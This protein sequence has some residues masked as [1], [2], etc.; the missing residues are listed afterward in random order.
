MSYAAVEPEVPWLGSPRFR[1]VLSTVILAALLL[2]L[3]G[4][5]RVAL[6][7]PSGSQVFLY[8]QTAL[9]PGKPASFRAF[10]L[11]SRDR[12]PLSGAA[13]SARLVSASGKSRPLAQ[14]MTGEDGTVQILGEIPPD[15]PEG[16]YRLAVEVD[17]SAGTS[18]VARDVSVKRSFRTMVSTDKPIY[19]P[20]QTIHIRT[21]SL[22]SSDLAPVEKRPVTIT[23]QDP[24]GNKVFK[25]L[26]TTSAYGIASA[27]FV[28]ADQVNTGDYAIEA[29]LGDTVSRRSVEVKVYTLPKYSIELSTER[30]FF[31]PGE[32]AAVTLRATYTFGKPVREA[33]IVITAQ[34]FIEKF[35]PF[36]QVRGETDAEG[37][38]RAE[39][40]LPRTFAGQGVRKGDA[41]LK[42]EAKVTDKA[43]HTQERSL[44]LT[45]SEEPIRVEVFPESGFLVPGVENVLYVLTAY[46]DGTP[47]ET[48]LTLGSQGQPVK[49]SSYGIAKITMPPESSRLDFTVKAVDA[50]GTAVTVT[51]TLK[52]G[53]V[54]GFILRTDKPVY[55]AGETAHLTLVSSADSGR[56]F[57]D[58]V[59]AGQ[60]VLMETLDIKNRKGELALDLGPDLAGT[61]EL[62]AYRL[63]PDGEFVRDTRVIQVEPATQLSIGVEL[64][65]ETYRPGEKAI[66]KFLVER[67]KG[68]PVQA[69]LSLAG[70]DEAVFALSEMRPGLEDVF[71]LLQEEILK[72]R[73]ELHAS[74]P[75]A[76]ASV[77]TGAETPVP[78]REEAKRVLFA[79]A[80]GRS[81]PQTTSS[82]GYQEKVRQVQ[83]EKQNYGRG[84]LAGAALL[85]TALFA[86]CVVLFGFYA[87]VRLRHR[88]PIASLS[89]ED[90]EELR[91]AS[92]RL[93]GLWMLA[94]Y[95]VLLAGI[96][97]AWLLGRVSYRHEK[98]AVV[99]AGLAF[100]AVFVGLL[101]ASRHWKMARATEATPLLR[102]ILWTV[103]AAN[104]A[105]G[106]G[107]LA[108]VAGLQ[109]HPRLIPE[110]AGAI[111][112][113]TLLAG[114]LL[115]TGFLSVARQSA[116]RPT[117]VGRW[118]WLL[119]SRP[120]ALALPALL[121]TFVAFAG[122]RRSSPMLAG[123][124]A[125]DGAFR[126]EMAPPPAA[127]EAKKQDVTGAPAKAGAPAGTLVE[128]TRVRRFFPETLFFLPEVIT[129][130]EG[131]AQVEIPLADSITTWRIGMSAVSAKG[132]LG[133]RDRGLRVFQDFFV[134]IDFPV[135]LT[136]HDFVSV[137]VA[138][139][140]YLPNAQT[141]QL[142]VQPADWFTLR[143]EA[144][145][146]LSI[147]P[148]QVTGVSLDIQAMRPGRHGLTV[149]ARGS[150]QAD[151]VERAV[152]VVP[153]GQPVVETYNGRLQGSLSKEFVIPPD[154]IDG[155][156]DLFVKVYPG[157]F[158]QVV[159]GLDS[160]FRMP[161]GC[162][163]Q[164]SSTTYP[165]VLVLGYL[166]RTKQAKPEIEMK[167][168]QYIN[169]GYQ[170]LLSYEVAGGGFEWFGHAPAHNVLTAY[171]LLEFHDMS[172][173]FE[174]DPAVLVRTRKWLYEQQKEDGTWAPST[175]GIAEGAI[176]AFQGAT[177][178]T[179][180]YI[181]WA[182]AET[183]DKDPRLARALDL[184][185]R[186][187]TWQDGQEDAYTLAL[188]GNALAAGGRNSEATPVLE[189]LM[190]LAIEEGEEIHWQPA[191]SGVTESRGGAFQIE[192]TA[193][194]AQALMRSQYSVGSA[195]KALAWLV[196]KKDSFGTWNSTQATIQAM[197]ALLGGSEPGG[198]KGN[199]KVTIEANG[200][201]I[202]SLAITPE[203]SDVFH[204]VSLREHVRSGGNKVSLTM[205]GEG[206]L[207]YQIVATHFVPWGSHALGKEEPAMSIEL[208]YDAR[209]V[210]KDA[211]L[212]VD[213]L[214]RY[215]RP[216]SAR[217]VVVDLGIPPGFELDPVSFE[218]MKA[219]GR[220]QRYSLTGRQVILYFEEVLHE[221]ALDFSYTLRAKYPVRAKT[222]VSAV[223]PYYE[224]EARA[225]ARPTE[226]AIQ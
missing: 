146:T 197:R 139:Y 147:G 105:A 20:G 47:A 223:Y 79:A 48:T 32:T 24:K 26:K 201:A 72:P 162:F 98:W 89:E 186:P 27:D 85:P 177:L 161:S 210:R 75:L 53:A 38:F 225:E 156:N 183:G 91:A 214:V 137:P 88:E 178:R 37:R 74:V 164:T 170:R 165:N 199:A 174:V 203:N 149:K 77:I 204:L 173:V 152:T 82:K 115:L 167:A 101:R 208:R 168:L 213:A 106:I 180:A 23:V 50:R 226:V 175:R 64:D 155:A 40:P 206:N 141:V 51:R 219:S 5:V 41:P 55:R 46:P 102:R 133:S 222:P 209:Q 143:G 8:G 221:K 134:D 54:N 70:V 7:K 104:L 211:L 198:G 218:E 22:H 73:W 25:A 109:S 36:A 200:A 169:L 3:V 59:K 16:S 68:E 163:E 195:H 158:S 110:A 111:A 61:V 217:M 99:F 80:S 44:D 86:C 39:I 123:R 4:S 90:R 84:V 193:I 129:D 122:A 120:A 67:R 62:H 71:F 207:A 153:D 1:R 194:A 151:A 138:V 96:G 12:R 154:A 87:I 6:K 118:F 196:S 78:E 202:P 100:L 15:L 185:A 43:G 176:N 188:I 35:R 205:T 127:A 56:V 52:P 13:V 116:L 132:E 148:G 66:L 30:G 17:S 2:F 9:S 179:T 18:E 224:P 135:T 31:Q 42:I 136:Q 60:T 29:V 166:R 113:G 215:N 65:K 33:A 92:G 93:L 21:L 58:A 108:L 125:D 131:K 114:T 150:A 144:V 97:S 112:L 171:G 172:K 76:P 189:K 83:A 187:S 192:T 10:V 216:G 107:L 117:G 126:N 220:L 190:K 49:T 142:E 69:A 191:S 94:P 95:L 157:A 212:R 14:A 121:V 159:E 28:L 182:L 124:I 81:A 181:A 103:P 140:N 130:T 19:Q 145:R 11:D 45:V 128:P 119:L 184:I 34:E 63:L 57:L 160:I